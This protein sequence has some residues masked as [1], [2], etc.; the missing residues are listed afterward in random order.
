MLSLQ[1]SPTKQMDSLASWVG[2]LQSTETKGGKTA[3]PPLT[4]AGI[5]KTKQ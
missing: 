3:F 5:R 1:V 2:P 4:G